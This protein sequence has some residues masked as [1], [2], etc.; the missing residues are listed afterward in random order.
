MA[1]TSMVLSDPARGLSYTL[2]PNDAVKVADYEVTATVRSVSE[3]HATA[4]GALDTTQWL[5]A[6]AVTIDLAAVNLGTP[7]AA[8][9]DSLAG[10]LLP[11]ARPYLVV[12]DSEW[13]SPR[14]IQVRFSSHTHPYEQDNYRAV[15]LAFVAPRGV[16][17]DQTIQ[18]FTLG[19]DVLDTTGFVFTDT[20]GAVVT[21]AAG[22]TFQPST[23][24]GSSIVT[25]A[26]NARP[27]WR[28]RLYGPAAGP[29]LT[30][31]TTGQS[32][33]FLGSLLLGAGDYLELDS[34]NRTALLLSQPDASRL[35]FMDF[36]NTEWFPFDPGVNRVRYHAA[37]GTGAGTAC[38]LTIYPVWLP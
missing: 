33:T 37:S 21:D 1:I 24:A 22:F 7:V 28:A 14:Q 3:D 9:M 34:A 29:V 35:A 26:G 38:F 30:N 12:T 27:A 25:V 32:I 15:Q 10:L 20:A 8:T 31:D 23:S 19:A 16:W 17:E 36:A 11:F 13:A 2:I 6:A 4:D 18:Q 5:S